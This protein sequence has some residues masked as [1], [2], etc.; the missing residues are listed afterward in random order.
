LADEAAFARA[1]VQQ[2]VIRIGELEREIEALK[3]VEQKPA[4]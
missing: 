3:T 1:Q 2:F 4:E